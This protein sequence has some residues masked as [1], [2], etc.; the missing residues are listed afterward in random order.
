MSARMCEHSRRKVNVVGGGYAGLAAISTICQS[1]GKFQV[2]LLEASSVL[3]GRVRT[4]NR[5]SVPIALG[6]TYFH[7][8]K[9]NSLLDL[10]FKHGVLKRGEGRE[11]PGSDEKTLQL[12]SDGTRLP[13]SALAS[14][15][16]MFPGRRPPAFL[17]KAS[18]FAPQRC[19]TTVV[20][21][22]SAA[23]R[24]TIA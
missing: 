7:G 2:E 8:E 11:Y 20:G 23:I 18:R 14:Y 16:N 24:L 1:G 19:G 5:T 3:G 6:A 12:L 15:E 22:L 9:T 13:E 17:E 4:T 10:A 21:A